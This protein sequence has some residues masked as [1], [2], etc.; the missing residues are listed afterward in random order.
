MFVANQPHEASVRRMDMATIRVPKEPMVEVHEGDFEVGA[1]TFPFF[2]L[3]KKHRYQPG[4]KGQ[5]I[6]NERL[7]EPSWHD[8]VSKWATFGCGFVHHDG[9]ARQPCRW[10]PSG[11]SGLHR[12]T[13]LAP[14]IRGRAVRSEASDACSQFSRNHPWYRARTEHAFTRLI[15]L[16]IVDYTSLDMT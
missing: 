10:Y 9:L 14:A 2:S 5:H 13:P 16:A 8:W 6:K 1:D 3:G 11:R 4:H 15:H 12:C 7:R